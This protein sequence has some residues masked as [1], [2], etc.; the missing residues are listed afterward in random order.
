MIECRARGEGR[1]RGGKSAIVLQRTED[2]IDYTEEVALRIEERRLAGQPDE[3]E[4]K[5]GGRDGDYDIEAGVSRDD[6]VAEGVTSEKIH[7]A[8]SAGR[9]GIRGDGATEYE[10]F[11]AINSTT[12]HGG[13][14]VTEGAL[15]KQPARP[16]AAPPPS[17]AVL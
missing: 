5:I 16:T 3:I 13:C 11:I 12:R 9:R 15:D 4:A 6:T 8:A 1:T 14:V 10:C 2:W 7:T 17:A